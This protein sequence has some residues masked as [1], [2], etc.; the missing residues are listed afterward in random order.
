MGVAGTLESDVA[1]AAYT[2]QNMLALLHQLERTFPHRFYADNPRCVDGGYMITDLTLEVACGW[3]SEM[4][5]FEGALR[6]VAIDLGYTYQLTSGNLYTVHLIDPDMQPYA[7]SAV[8]LGEGVLPVI[9]FANALLKSQK[10]LE[11]Y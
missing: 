11:V 7:E 1:M 10:T 6:D 8:L 4:M 3:R 2:T 9:A 5:K